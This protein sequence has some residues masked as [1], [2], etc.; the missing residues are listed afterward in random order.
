MKF[1]I[2]RLVRLLTRMHLWHPR[3]NDDSLAAARRAQAEL[4][5][6]RSDAKVVDQILSTLADVD[7]RSVEQ[8]EGSLILAYEQA[9]GSEAFTDAL[10][11]AMKGQV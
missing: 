2:D 6:S 5:A 4:A 10:T 9:R 11:R 1:L 8:L 3:P 7:R